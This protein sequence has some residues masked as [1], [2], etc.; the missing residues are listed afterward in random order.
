MIRSRTAHNNL[1]A[2]L[3]EITVARIA[4]ELVTVEAA[5]RA[6]GERIGAATPKCYLSITA[7]HGW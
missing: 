1:V 2:E 6:M 7:L 5:E 3:N 4:G